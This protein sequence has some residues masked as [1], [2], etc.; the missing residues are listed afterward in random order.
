MPGW[1]ASC[2]RPQRRANRRSWWAARTSTPRSPATPDEAEEAA[3]TIIA[4]HASAYFYDAP[5]ATSKPRSTAARPG[6]RLR[7]ARLWLGRQRAPDRL[8]RRERFPAAA[9]QRGGPGAGRPYTVS[10]RLI[11]NVGELALEAEQGTL[12]RRSQAASFAGLARRP[13]AG[14]RSQRRRDVNEAS[15]YI[16]IPENCVGTA[17]AHRIA[18][19]YTISSSEPR[20]GKF[21]TRNTAVS[22]PNAVLLGGPKEEPLPDSDE[23]NLESGLF[24]AFNA[25]TDEGHDQRRGAQLDADRDGAGGQRAPSLR[26]RARPQVSALETTAPV[27][28][29]RPAHPHPRPARPP[30]RRRFPCRRRRRPPGPARAQATRALYAGAGAVAPLLPFLP[31]PIPTPAR[32]SPPSGTSAVTSPV[33][34]AEHEEESEEAPESVSN[35]AVAYRSAEHEPTPPTSSGSSR[36]PRSPEPPL[37]AVAPR[38]ARGAPRRGRGVS[39]RRRGRHAAR[40]R[41]GEA[42]PGSV[43]ARRTPAAAGHVSHSHNRAFSQPR[44]R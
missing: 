38:P 19:E 16:P 34:I 17:C 44:N 15:L 23:Q 4:G 13:R 43:A 9:R 5:E 32:P 31:P 25:G 29:P 18:P 36:W 21:V 24:C 11:P 3:Q 42:A 40:A 30:R 33:E 10:A 26:D 8:P 12:L 28:P 22:E 41:A 27:P 1:K 39:L 20:I 2:G 35:Q 37:A 7:H 14:G 6:V